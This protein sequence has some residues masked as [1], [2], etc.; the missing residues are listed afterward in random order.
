MKHP[1]NSSYLNNLPICIIIILL[2]VIQSPML[3]QMIMDDH[4]VVYQDTIN[5]S[6]DI[7]QQ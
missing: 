6:G 3:L 5:K 4:L 2:S 7:T 1:Q